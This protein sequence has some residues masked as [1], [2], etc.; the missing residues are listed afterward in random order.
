MTW[1]PNP[2][3]PCPC[4]GPELAE[5][6]QSRPWL[7]EWERAMYWPDV[8][9]EPIGDSLPH[10]D[11]GEWIERTDPAPV[12]EP[13]FEP[14]QWTEAEAAAKREWTAAQPRPSFIDRIRNATNR[15]RK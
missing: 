12:E 4:C 14:Y 1:R 13:R 10:R 3:P 11:V 9:A 2:Q 15:K 6:K 8:D 7:S 5:T